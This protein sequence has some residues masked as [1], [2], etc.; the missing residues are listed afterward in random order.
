MTGFLLLS[1]TQAVKKTPRLAALS[2]EVSDNIVT[3]QRTYLKARALAKTNP[4]AEAEV[5]KAQVE[6]QAVRVSA[7]TASP[8]TVELAS[9]TKPA[10]AAEVASLAQAASDLDAK[11]QPM[12]QSAEAL[13]KGLIWAALA[14]GVVASVLS[15]FNFNRASAA[16]SALVVVASGTP[17]V[18][19]VHER[20]AY[21]QTIAHQST[22]LTS[23]LALAV[24]L[25]S[26]LTIDEY[27][28]DVRKR[29][30][31]EDALPFPG[32]AGGDPT[33]DLLTKLDATKISTLGGQ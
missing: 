3:A 21:Y 1:Q 4:A 16:V 14:L 20:A 15:S 10:P 29:Q 31:L 33:P 22:S 24:A 8:Q 26:Q 32:T 17:N 13:E 27:D 25:G 9:A 2:Q 7:A 23:A 19:P 30:A 11:V 5:K 28:N 18:Y 6:L 12:A